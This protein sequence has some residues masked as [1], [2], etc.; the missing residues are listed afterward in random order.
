MK[1]GSTLR[2]GSWFLLVVLIL[3]GIT[4]ALDPAAAGRAIDRSL[5]LASRLFPILG[6]V[7]LVI[8]LSNLFLRPDWIRNH[9]GAGSGPLGWLLAAIGGILAAGPVYPW[10]AL[11]GDLRAKGM[12]HALMAVFLYTRAI[13]LPLLPWLVHYF[14][15]AYTLILLGYMVLLAFP[16]GLL[17]ERLVERGTPRGSGSRR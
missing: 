17:L 11:L 15:L 1:A 6:I 5:T 2:G 16:S 10:Y 14:G 4:Y 8:F 7:A 3:Y 9:L 12:R 13:K